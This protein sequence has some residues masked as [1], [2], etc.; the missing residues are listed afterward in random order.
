MLSLL[1][2]HI[3]KNHVGLYRDDGL[4]ILKNTS[5]PEAAKL[6]NVSKI[7]LKKYLDII[8]QCNLKVINYIDLTLNLNDGSY[9]LTENPTKN[10]YIFTSI[11]TTRH[12]SLK[13]FHNQLK[14]DSQFCYHL[15]IFFRSQPFTTKNA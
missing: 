2:K 11:Q 15:K 7:I 4:A 14:K 1:S 13:K 5:V 10:P 8:V 3:N 12:Q 6:K 9:R